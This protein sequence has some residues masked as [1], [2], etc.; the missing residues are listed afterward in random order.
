MSEII[1]IGGWMVSLGKRLS[2]IIVLEDKAGGSKSVDNKSITFTVNRLLFAFHLVIRGQSR[3]Q[4][5][6]R[7]MCFRFYII[8]KKHSRHRSNGFCHRLEC[9]CYILINI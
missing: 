1:V 4:S 2:I 3:R 5:E 6:S 8:Y 7:L 9:Q